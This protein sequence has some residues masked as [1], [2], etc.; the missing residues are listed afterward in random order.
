[1]FSRILVGVDGSEHGARAL[2]VATELAV[3][4]RGR[5]SLMSIVPHPSPWAWGGPFSPDELRRDAERYYEAVLRKAVEAVP[6]QVPTVLHVRHGRAADR[7]LDEVRRDH[8]DLI[9]VDSR[10]RGRL[11]SALFGGLGPERRS[12]VPILVVPVPT[13]DVRGSEQGRGRELDLCVSNVS[14]VTRAPPRE[15]TSVS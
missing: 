12:P 7:L 5:L 10:N 13:P 2:A 9:V 6:A 14:I 15:A 3:A 11:R 1:M 4:G 8:Y